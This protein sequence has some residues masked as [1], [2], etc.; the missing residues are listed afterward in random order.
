MNII[1]YKKNKVKPIINKELE[2]F[3]DQQ[4]WR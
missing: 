4:I 1:N 3:I 2:P